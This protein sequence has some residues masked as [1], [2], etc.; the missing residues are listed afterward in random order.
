MNTALLEKHISRYI[1]NID[2]DKVSYEQ[3]RKERAERSAYYQTWTTEKLNVMTEEEFY[4]FIAKLWAMLIW[5]NKKYVVDKLIANNSFQIIKKELSKLLW[6][7][8]AI[9]KKQEPVKG[10]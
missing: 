8:S 10:S 7:D 2:A 5:G 3:D 6:D 4:E 9:E 1:K